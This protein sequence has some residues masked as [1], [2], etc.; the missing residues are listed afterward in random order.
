MK[1]LLLISFFITLFASGANAQGKF[2]LGIIIGEP[3]GISMKV[4]LSGTSA[5]DGA[6]GWSFAKYSSLHVHAD[7]LNVIARIAPQVPL[8]IG[9]GGRF[10][11]NN[12]DKNQDSHLGIRVPFGLEYTPAST[13]IDLFF[14]VVPVMD[15]TPTTDF[16]FNAAAGVRYYF[17]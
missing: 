1:K 10:K 14:E 16:N 12:S 13:P 4:K 5:V 15:L 17:N 2:G 7:Y 3:T 9:I 11:T 6:L 8:Y